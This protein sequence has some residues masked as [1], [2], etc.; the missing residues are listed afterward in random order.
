L[1]G[2]QPIV[3]EIEEVQ[4]IKDEQAKIFHLYEFSKYEE[5]TYAIENDWILEILKELTE[6]SEPAQQKR[7]TSMLSASQNATVNRRAI[8]LQYVISEECFGEGS[9][10]HFYTNLTTTPEEVWRSSRMRESVRTM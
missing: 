8:L 6:F 7:Q 10:S 1:C 5:V 9:A 4:H 2:I 3:V